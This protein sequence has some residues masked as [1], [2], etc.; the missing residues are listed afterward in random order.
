[1]GDKFDIIVSIAKNNSVVVAKDRH[2]MPAKLHLVRT[3]CVDN[4][5]LNETTAHTIIVAGSECG[6]STL[7]SRP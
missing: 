6:P 3:R 5:N 1:L 4:A 2:M 7:H